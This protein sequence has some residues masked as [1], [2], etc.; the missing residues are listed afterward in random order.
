LVTRICRPAQI[1][2]AS[3]MAI[4]AAFAMSGSVFHGMVGLA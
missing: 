3:M 2:A 1:A 4:H